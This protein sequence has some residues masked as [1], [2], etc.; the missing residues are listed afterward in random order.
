VPIAIL[1]KDFNNAPLRAV[2]QIYCRRE[3]EIT[4]LQAVTDES[5]LLAFDAAAARPEMQVVFSGGGHWT[6]ML[7][8]TQP[9]DELVCPVLP[10]GGDRM[11][12][13]EVMGIETPDPTA[14]D[15][16]AVGVVDTPCPRLAGIEHVT[17][18]N[19]SGKK[20][21]PASASLPSHGEMVCRLIG[22]RMDDP[23]RFGGLAPGAMITCINAESDASLNPAIVSAAIVKLARDFDCDLIN[24]SAGRFNPTQGIRQAISEAREYGTLC[25]VAAGNEPRDHV[26]YPARYSE[27][28]AVGAI[29]LKGWGPPQSHARYLSDWASSR[30]ERVGRMGTLDLFHCP[31]SAYGAGLNVVGPGVGL[32]IYRDTAPV[33]DATGTS[34]AAPLVTGIMA[35][36]LSKSDTYKDIPRSA[37]RTVFAEELLR[38]VCQ[39][40]GLGVEREG[41]GLPRLPLRVTAPN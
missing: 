31:H 37:E 36:I 12:W 9:P 27:C 4:P 13:H 34:F 30:P 23:H 20:Y 10:D 25:I 28:I 7:D 41:L 22:Q 33:C 26:S 32:I 29:G 1:L 40:T 16:I 19:L 21:A 38:S 5:G 18:L 11:W 15:G 6:L 3:G 8:A 17:M 14:G 2:G 24:L 39:R 35:R